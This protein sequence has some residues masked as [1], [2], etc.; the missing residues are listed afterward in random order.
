MKTFSILLALGLSIPTAEGLSLEYGESF[1]SEGHY[2]GDCLDTVN[3]KS[4]YGIV[5]YNCGRKCFV[6]FD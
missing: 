4:D 6:Y 1:G 2:A 3:F 5:D